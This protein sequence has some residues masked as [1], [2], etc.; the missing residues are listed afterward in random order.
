MRI[1]V[2][3]AVFLVLMPSIAAIT[4]AELNNNTVAYW[5]FDDTYADENGQFD[6]TNNGMTFDTGKK[7]SAAYGQSGDYLNGTRVDLSTGELSVFG[8]MK[9]DTSVKPQ[10]IS[11]R[12]G[13]S[14]NQFQFQGATD[15]TAGYLILWGTPSAQTAQTPT[16]YF[17]NGTWTHYGFT[18]DGSTVKFYKNGAEISSSSEVVTLDNTAGSRININRDHYTNYGKAWF[19]EMAV[20]NESLTAEKVS[21]LYN[22]TNAGRQYVFATGSPANDTINFS[23]H[24]R[25]TSA[26]GSTDFAIFVESTESLSNVTF[27][28]DNGTGTYA[29]FSS[30][31]PSA[32]STWSNHTTNINATNGAT[33]R[34]YWSASDGNLTENSST[35]TF[36]IYVTPTGTMNWTR[37]PNNP[38]RAAANND[39][40]ELSGSVSGESN[41]WIYNGTVFALYRSSNSTPSPVYRILLTNSTDAINWGNRTNLTGQMPSA[42]FQQPQVQR[43]GDTLYL[44]GVDLTHDYLWVLNAS[45]SNPYNW[46]QMCGGP[47]ITYETSREVFN[48]AFDFDAE[49]NVHMYLEEKNG[50]QF[51]LNYYNATSICGPY[52]DGGNKHPN[53][54]NAWLKRGRAVDN[55]SDVWVMVTGNVSTSDWTG[56]YFRGTD[57][58]DLTL[59]ENTILGG[60]QESWETSPYNSIADFDIMVWTED[61][62]ITLPY[63]TVMYYNGGQ[64]EDGFAYDTGNRS[65]E[66]VFNF[67]IVDYFSVEAAS[68]STTNITSVSLTVND[69]SL[70]AGDSITYNLT[71]DPSNATSVT[72]QIDFGDESS[73]AT[74]ADGTHTYATAGTYTL[75]VDATDGQGNTAS[76]STTITVTNPT[77]ELNATINAWDL[78]G[79]YF[80][81]AGASLDLVMEVNLTATN[82]AG[83]VADVY[84]DLPL[85]LSASGL[86]WYTGDVVNRT[87]YTNESALDDADGTNYTWNGTVLTINLTSA[88]NENYTYVLDVHYD[89]NDTDIYLVSIND[90]EYTYNNAAKAWD[91]PDWVKFQLNNSHVVFEPGQ[92]FPFVEGINN[93]TVGHPCFA[94]VCAAVYESITMDMIVLREFGSEE[95]T[96]NNTDGNTTRFLKTLSGGASVSGI[97]RMTAQNA[98]TLA[99]TE[100]ATNDTYTNVI[101]ATSLLST[102]IGQHIPVNTIFYR[103]T[104]PANFADGTASVQWYNETAEAYQ[105]ISVTQYF[106]DTDSDGTTDYFAFYQPHQ[107]SSETYRVT[108]TCIDCDGSAEVGDAGGSSGSG[109]GS[110]SSDPVVR[111]VQPSSGK[112]TGLFCPVDGSSGSFQVTLE[113]VGTT[114][115][116]VDL[117]LEG[118]ECQ[119]STDSLS[120]SPSG[121]ASFQVEGCMCPDAYGQS[122][123]GSIVVTA[124]AS[125]LERIEVSLSSLRLDARTWVLIGFAGFLLFSIVAV[126]L[127]LMRTR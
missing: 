116:S 109:G 72:Y 98:V 58:S 101:N 66:E 95:V 19:D 108:A 71:P 42:T 68:V 25:S 35:Y 4:D 87:Y 102:A 62:N 20:Y 59:I 93:I 3:L 69:T 24:S 126:I 50:G 60:G 117:A 51:Y 7:N 15:F 52:T 81:D 27:Y 64:V 21:A 13:S 124:G 53:A 5:R 8:W 65:I 105:A 121:F 82:P 88:P 38:V 49:G 100:T 2:V 85:N 11:Q 90:R 103:M 63:K 29:Q 94:E 34:Y 46:N 73:N 70:T 107:L 77:E 28:L 6:L 112:L 125:V 16:G 119:L 37:Y 104:V 41:Q 1:I 32:T 48:P 12:D 18:F 111:V 33:I 9:I 96:I 44:M 47:I 10:I 61:H 22:E 114:L 97:A 55:S 14:I 115:A 67:T 54:G 79:R 26:G 123:D 23:S 84:I 45:I 40:M 120:I 36:D 76:N 113:N 75:S 56:T 17:V 80:V 99:Q 31:N 30:T 118:V 122:I 127:S 39:P 106:I 91:P 57:P 74:A 83:S 89:L 92:T 86:T 43:R 78:I 110:V